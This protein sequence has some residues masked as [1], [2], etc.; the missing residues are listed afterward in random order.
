MEVEKGKTF[1]YLKD[2][3]EV[4]SEVI[5]N[6]KYFNKMK[7]MI[8]GALTESKMTIPQL[9]KKINMPESEVV[10]YLMTLVKYGYVQTAEVD[11]MDE[12]FYYKIK[13]NG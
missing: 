11:D 12:Y 5:E 10:Y 4:S 9:T 7:K 8:I 2:K 6:L 1:K 13:N 3:R